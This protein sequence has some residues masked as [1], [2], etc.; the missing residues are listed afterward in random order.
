MKIYT[1]DEIRKLPQ[2]WVDVK[3]ALPPIGEEVWC[4]CPDK[5]TRKITALVRL[6][7]YEESREF[8]WDNSYGGGNMHLGKS[9]THW[10]PRPAPPNS[11]DCD[12]SAS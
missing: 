4:Y 8:H 3:D 2:A 6:I 5:L 11:G 9:V 10:M 12:A 7:P 1:E